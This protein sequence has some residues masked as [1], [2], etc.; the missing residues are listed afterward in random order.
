MDDSPFCRRAFEGEKLYEGVRAPAFSCKNW[1]AL[2]EG[3]LRHYGGWLSVRAENETDPL[4]FVGRLKS[5][6]DRYLTM[7]CVGADGSWYPE[8]ATLSLS[9]LTSVSFGD[10]YLGVF[11]K[12]CKEK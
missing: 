12:Y 10:R 9:E 1:S 4:F 8:P 6:D 11:K 5:H 3:I 2:L 7:R